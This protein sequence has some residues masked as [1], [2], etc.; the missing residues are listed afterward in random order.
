M[1]K[2]GIIEGYETEIAYQKHMIENLGRW[3]SLLFIIASIG[4]VI[5]I[6]FNG[7]ILLK[8]LG[9]LL[10]LIGSLGML[11]FGYGIYKGKQNVSKVIDDLEQ[12]LKSV[13]D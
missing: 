8:I 9:L 11:L 1:T 13:N 7:H 10:V 3:F 12:T 2:Q 4:V 5:F 6:F